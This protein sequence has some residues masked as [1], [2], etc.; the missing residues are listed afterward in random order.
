MLGRCIHIII[1]F[2]VRLERFFYTRD[3]LI[4]ATI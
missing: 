3:I 4:D 1:S 2:T